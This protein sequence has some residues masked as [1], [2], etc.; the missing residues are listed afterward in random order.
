MK[1]E[2]KAKYNIGAYSSSNE[3]GKYSIDAYSESNI[4]GGIFSTIDAGAEF[5]VKS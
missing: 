5:F 4:Y 2:K 1:K 3:E